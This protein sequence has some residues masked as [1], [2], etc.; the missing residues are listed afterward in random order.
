MPSGWAWYLKFLESKTME[1]FVSFILSSVISIALI[2]ILIKSASML[3]MVDEPDERKVHTKAIPRCGGLGLAIAALSV[4]LLLL[5]FEGPI[6]RLL[7]GGGIIV[8]FGALD[9]MLNLNYKWKFFGQ[10]LAVFVMV[11]GGIYLK[12]LP[13]AGLDP[14]PLWIAYPLTV[15]FVVGVTNAVNLSDGLDGLAAGIMLMTVS[16]IAF[17]S[18]L[19]DSSSLAIMALALAGGIVG[20]LRF[21]THP[22]IVFMG[23]TGSQFI[24]FMA[25]S[26]TIFLI[27]D[28]HQTLNPA[29]P[30]LILGLPILDTLTVMVQRIR[31]GLSP[32]SPDKR[33]IHH[34]LLRLGFTHAEAVGAIYILQA[35]FLLASFFLRYKSDSVVLGFYLS[36][37]FAI[38]LFF[39]GAARLGWMLHSVQ[40]PIERRRSFFRRFNWL[41]KFSKFYIEYSLAIFIG[42]MIFA[43]FRHA[44]MFTQLEMV[45]A[46]AFLCLFWFLNNPLKETLTRLS[47]YA[48]GVFSCLILNPSNGVDHWLVWGVDIFFA[49]LLIVV[50]LAVQVTRKSVFS[51]T[52]QDVLVGLF[53]LSAMFLADIELLP[54]ILFRLFCLGYAVEYLFHRKAK[55]YR[56]LKLLAMFSGVMILLIVLPGVVSTMK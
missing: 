25:A 13:F 22:A 32:F 41:Y 37:C 40:E 17:Y 7:I 8:L 11:S 10:F 12:F 55:E 48:A 5:P 1:L 16:A 53:I 43:M 29:L 6:G 38:L 52:T 27:V 50:F 28:V 19:V 4:I 42:V 20:F 49:V 9:D 2:P 45:F 14:A 51:L 33:H 21:N 39:Y 36:I 26:F 23:D 46:I 31:S 24:G 34:R 3:N 54:R 56:P 44:M 30:L 15:L 18:A 35:L 47:I